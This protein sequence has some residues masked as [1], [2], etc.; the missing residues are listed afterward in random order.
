MDD[1]NVVELIGEDGEPVSFEHLMTLEHKGTSYILL[2]PVEPET[3]DEEGSVVIMRIDRDANEADCYVVEENEEVLDAV[4]NRF[5]DL[6]EEE[7][8]DEIDMDDE[9]EDE[10]DE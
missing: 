4:F 9:P 8:Q 6:V 3:P 10:D 1:E 5:L 7:E 2:S